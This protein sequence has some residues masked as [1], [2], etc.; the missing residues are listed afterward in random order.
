MLTASSSKA[1]NNGFVFN[2]IYKISLKKKKKERLCQISSSF[3]H[4]NFFLSKK[5]NKEECYQHSFNMI[6]SHSRYT[7]QNILIAAYFFKYIT[8]CNWSYRTYLSKWVKRQIFFNMFLSDN[9]REV[10]FLS[11]LELTC[12]FYFPICLQAWVG[13]CSTTVSVV[14]YWVAI[15]TA[16]DMSHQANS[17]CNQIFN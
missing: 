10:V 14:T 7:Q 12:M 3:S 13:I 15:R 11:D 5:K 8:Q 2:R 1:S 9:A 6:G 16:E 4:L 17:K